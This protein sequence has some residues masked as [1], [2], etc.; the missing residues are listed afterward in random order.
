MLNIQVSDAL[1]KNCKHA[2]CG[3]EF[4]K[5]ADKTFLQAASQIICK[6]LGLP[7]LAWLIQL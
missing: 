5:Q 7:Y 1:V 2:Y 4:T 6:Y 3:T